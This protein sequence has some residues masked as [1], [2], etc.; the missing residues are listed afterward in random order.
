MRFCNGGPNWAGLD[1]Q[2][3]GSTPNWCV[4]VGRYCIVP[5]MYAALSKRGIR[6][7]N[8]AAAQPGYNNMIHQSESV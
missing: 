1:F 5:R 3:S 2:A 8:V 7:T 6:F 4:N